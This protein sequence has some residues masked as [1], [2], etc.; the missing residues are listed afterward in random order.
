[1][2]DNVRKMVPEDEASKINL[3]AYWKILW[4][5]KF[6]L[7]VPLVLAGVIAVYGVKHL[8]PIYESTTMIS[9]EEKNVLSA[10]MERYLQGGEDRN[11]MRDQ[12]N[13]AMIETRLKSRDFLEYAARE[14]GLDRSEDV[15]RRIEATARDGQGGLSVDELVMRY[16]VTVLREKIKVNNPQPGFVTIGVQDTDP[17]TAYVLAQ[18][19]SELFIDVTKQEQIKGFRQAG[20]FS[21]EQLAI[22]KDKLDASEKELSRVKREMAGSSVES[23]PV[24]AANINFAQALKQTMDA[25]VEK[26]DIAMKRVRDRLNALFNLVPSSD[27]I[28]S[29]EAV[30]NIER[31][32][33]AY[34]EE[35]LLND[36]RPQPQQEAKTADPFASITDA[37][38]SRIKELVQNEYRTVSPDMYPLIVEYFY[39]RVLLDYYTA[40]ARTLQR[41][42]DQ[43]ATNLDQKP[44]LER[45]LNRLTQEVETNRAVYKAFQDSKTS[46]R[47]NEAAQTTNLS[48]NVAIIERAEK[49]LIPVKP[50]PLKIIIVALFFGGVCGFGAILVTEYIDDSFRSVEEV[51]RVLKVPVLGTIPKMMTGFAWERRR[52]GRMILFWIVGVVV[53]VAMMSGVFYVYGKLLKGSG[54]GIELREDRAAGEVKQ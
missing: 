36:L 50:A 53:F 25:E 29:D 9:I 11:Q 23:N 10:T 20:T 22:Y 4:R 5:K 49:P 2:V 14:L 34:G 51:E 19:I 16:F 41:Y 35:K 6:Y 3:H 13:R 48:M 33:D 40:T 24:T 32:L 1:M 30:A 42:I 43:Y 47:I 15:R 18:K 38:R 52:H 8:T 44:A 21:D 45:E 27:R 46:A 17:T 54:L 37:L 12:Q 31:Q 39:Q 28:S 26:N 7:V